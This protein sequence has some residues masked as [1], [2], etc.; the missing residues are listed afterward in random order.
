MNI[1]CCACVLQRLTR[2]Y[3]N[4]KFK[5]GE[6]DDGY[7]VKLKLK[8]YTSYMSTT[9]DDSP[10]YIFDASFGEV[11][12]SVCVC[13]CVDACVCCCVTATHMHQHTYVCINTY[14][15][16]IYVCMYVCA[17]CQCVHDFVCAL[18]K[19]LHVQ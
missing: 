8:Y 4:Q 5:C 9:Q 18:S 13:C 17:F 11:C 6:D 19:F 1:L 3:R 16:Y 7:S 10:L 14:T 12:V 15:V 2:K